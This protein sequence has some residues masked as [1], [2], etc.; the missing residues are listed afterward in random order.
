VRTLVSQ[1]ADAQP[2]P[3]VEAELAAPQVPEPDSS[4]LPAEQ[5]LPPQEQQR[6][7]QPVAPDSVPL[8]APVA[9]RPPDERAAELP[10]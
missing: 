1:A 7:V 8:W 4:A 3:L 2:V 6:E 5:A 10:A 9:R